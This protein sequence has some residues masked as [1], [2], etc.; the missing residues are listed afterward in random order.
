MMF[1]IELLILIFSNID[2]KTR[3]K[4]KRV[5]WQWF[6]IIMTHFK[7]QHNTLTIY[8]TTLDDNY[9]PMVDLLKNIL[10]PYKLRIILSDT[11]NCTRIAPLGIW[12]KFS[13]IIIYNLY[14]CIVQFNYLIESWMVSSSCKTPVK[15]VALYG[16]GIKQIKLQKPMINFKNE[17]F[18]D[19]FT[20]NKNANDNTFYCTTAAKLELNS[21]VIKYI[22]KN[23]KKFPYEYS[24]AVDSDSSDEGEITNCIFRYKHRPYN[25][26]DYK[27]RVF[28]IV[29]TNTPYCK[30]C[31]KKLKNFKNV[32]FLMIR[33]CG[34]VDD[35]SYLNT[36]YNCFKKLKSLSLNF[37][38][39]NYNVNETKQLP[40]ITTLHLNSFNTDYPFEVITK[41]FP[42]L[43][44]FTFKGSHLKNDS[45]YP[46]NIHIEN[47]LMNLPNLQHIKLNCP[48][49]QHIDLTPTFLLHGLKLQVCLLYFYNN[50]LFFIFI[51]FIT[52]ICRQLKHVQSLVMKLYSRIYHIYLK[53]SIG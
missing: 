31:T 49:I 11:F 33:I 38:N 23:T 12:D 29:V 45:N 34:N 6:H 26:Y 9:K 53:L 19:C 50:T 37:F 39:Y 16:N 47:L 40:N 36:Y 13:S 8:D 15:V 48:T 10:Y 3:L 4:C 44:I 42:N 1:P 14:D 20:F 7:Q 21:F 28:R 51:T 30:Y 35:T 24:N 2:F 22:T 17:P 25:R 46:I 43:R 5:C 52:F 27:N 18:F 32:N 41:K